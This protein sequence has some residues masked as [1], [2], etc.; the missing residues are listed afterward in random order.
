MTGGVIM[1]CEWREWMRKRRRS[2]KGVV[3]LI[4]VVIDNDNM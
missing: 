2:R 1:I 4:I 3:L